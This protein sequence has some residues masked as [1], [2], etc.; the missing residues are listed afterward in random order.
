MILPIDGNHENDSPDSF[1]NWSIPGVAGDPYAE[2]YA[3]FDV[4]SVHFVLVDDMH[5]SNI[6]SG[7]S[8]T[9]GSAQL[10]WLDADLAAAVADRTA[11]PFIV[12]LS[13]RGLFSTSNHAT[14]SDVHNARGQLAPLYDKYKVDLAVNG[15]DHEYERSKPLHAGNP[16]SGDPVVGAG[17][18][19]IINAGAGADPYAINTS[20]QPYSSGV[21]V[22]FCGGGTSCSSSPYIGLYSI[23]TISATSVKATVYGLKPSSTSIMDDTVID[24]LTLTPQ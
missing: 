2:T 4:G 7:A 20:P 21:Q 24:T 11:H 22:G 14:D 1:A 15:H 18:Q 19:Y 5:I 17:T 8:D 6:T 10:K 23:F 3:S 16:P 12:A 13:H 9:E